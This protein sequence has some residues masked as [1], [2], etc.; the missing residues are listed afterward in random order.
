MKPTGYTVAVAFGCGNLLA[1]AKALRAKV[2]RPTHRLAA[3]DDGTP[4]NPG[5]TKAREAAAAVGALL[6]VPDFGENRPAA[7]TDFNDMARH[8]GL[9]AVEEGVERAE[10]GATA[11]PEGPSYWRE[12]ARLQGVATFIEFHDPRKP[13]RPRAQTDI[14][15][16]IGQRVAQALFLGDDDRAYAVVRDRSEVW[17][18]ASKR[19]RD[20]CAAAISCS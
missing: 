18:V 16:D 2:P 12:Q 6:A 19:F 14:L 8:R 15:I 9:D 1:V 4:G 17:P 7:A 13:P 5:L 3:D 10:P 20:G 11:A